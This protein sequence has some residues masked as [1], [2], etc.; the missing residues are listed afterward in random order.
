[1]R[2]N[3]VLPPPFPLAVG[4]YKFSSPCAPHCALDLATD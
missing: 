1:M 3:A 4:Y 2:A